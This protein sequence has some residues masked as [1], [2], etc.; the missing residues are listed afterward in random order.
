MDPEYKRFNLRDED[1]LVAIIVTLIAAVLFFF[2]VGRGCRPQSAEI[3]DGN[4]ILV[5]EEGVADQIDVPPGVTVLTVDEARE[6]GIEATPIAQ[7]DLQELREEGELTV[8]ALDEDGEESEVQLPFIAASVAPTLGFME[9]RT[10][11]FGNI[12]IDGQGEPDTDVAVIVDG[13]EIGRSRVNPSGDW[14]YLIPRGAIGVGNHDVIAR[15]GELSSDVSSFTLNAP[16]TPRF[17]SQYSDQV[18]PDRYFVRG[19]A[20]ANWQVGLRSAGDNVQIIETDSNGNWEALLD[21]TQPGE[22]SLQAFA[23]NP[24][25]T[26]N[27][28]AGTDR[29]Q[30]R[31][32]DGV[33]SLAPETDGIVPDVEVEPAATET[34]VGE[35]EAQ[36][37]VEPATETPAAPDEEMTT[38]AQQLAG[39]G[40]FTT[41]AAAVEAAGLT[42]ALDQQDSP[43]TLFAPTDEAFA[44]LPPGVVDAYLT[45]PTALQQLLT[46][47]VVPGSLSAADL[48][49]F[50]AAEPPAVNNLAGSTL[51]LSTDGEL[52]TIAGNN[53]TV[54]DIAV[55]NG[56]IHAIDN[57]I[58]PPA[59]EGQSPTIDDSGVPTFR[60]TVLTI[61][62]TG[63]PN[64]MLT[65]M[66]NNQV[67]GTAT[68]DPDGR[69]LIVNDIGIGEYKIVA[70]AVGEDGL[71]QGVSNTV[72]LTVE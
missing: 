18:P 35:E 58:L 31:V 13:E 26:P 61:V 5:V 19:T 43:V 34:P 16:Q 62:G 4:S 30:I 71:L 22:Y 57:L 32:A 20:D 17:L 38:V 66:V 67:H 54:S 42:A 37:P 50:M 2:V 51:L 29:I 46:E 40:R 24:D 11:E 21:L 63:E 23:I 55:S 15:S 8:D 6:L 59:A 72:R 44:A 27:L 33:E 69:W 3:L 47:H 25:G 64:T 39:D 68:V 1:E 7:S 70:Y 36:V 56:Y 53:V 12:L 41:L 9:N 28:Q 14:S 10:F 48:V 52:V 60:G 45:N 49:N 65:V